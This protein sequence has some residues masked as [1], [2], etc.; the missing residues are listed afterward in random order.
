ML[1]TFYGAILLIEVIIT[2]IVG[3][4]IIRRNPAEK[5]NQVYLVVL[6]SFAIYPALESLLYLF[7]I[8]DNRQKASSI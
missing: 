6:L 1:D 4:F 3:L 7:N 2:V 8:T 5:L